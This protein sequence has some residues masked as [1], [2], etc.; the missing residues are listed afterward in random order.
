MPAGDGYV[1][2]PRWN[3]TGPRTR[4]RPPASDGMCKMLGALV[5]MS[6]AGGKMGMFHSPPPTP[7]SRAA[8]CGRHRR[9]PCAEK[10]EKHT[11]SGTPEFDQTR[12]DNKHGEAKEKESGMYSKTSRESRQK[13]RESRSNDTLS[14]WCRS[15]PK[16]H[17]TPATNLNKKTA[18]R[19]RGVGIGDVVGQGTKSAKPNVG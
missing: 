15:S 17:K 5:A 6:A 10:A 18:S 1:L 16:T 8:G 12:G 13:Q 9:I 4:M 2:L 19:H 11:C 7:G 14:G 3:P